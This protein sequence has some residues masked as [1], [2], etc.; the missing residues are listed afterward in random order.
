MFSLKPFFSFFLLFASI[1]C[2]AAPM[3]FKG[4][5]MTMVE[6]TN[7][8]KRFELSHVITGNE[9]IG[10][11]FFNIQDKQRKVNGGGIFYLNRLKRINRINSQT[12]LW[13]YLELGNIDNRMS[14]NRQAY[15]SPTFQLD[16]ETKRFYSSL[17]HQ[18][19]RGPHE[20][21]DRTQIKSG[22]S[23]YD[24]SYEETQPWFILE[25][26]NMHSL[27]HNP[28]FIPPLRFVNKTLFF[29][30]GISTKGDPKLHLMYTF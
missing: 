7:D 11:R 25:V 6:G 26:M 13:F 20:N 30:A 9:S 10:L 23:F 18:I 19:L 17:S 27:E 15:L 22:F 2:F 3:T 8:F 4:S 5:T 28:A 16:Y 14:K 24:T 29:E 1:N 12:N 21:F